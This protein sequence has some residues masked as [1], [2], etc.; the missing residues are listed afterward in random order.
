MT[1]SKD[2]FGASITE[3]ANHDEYTQAA[4]FGIYYALANRITPDDA[5]PGTITVL[6]IIENRVDTTPDT[7]AYTAAFATWAL[8]NTP[9]FYEPFIK[10]RQVHF[11]GEKP[12]ISQQ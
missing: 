7:I 8:L 4:S 12:A 3:W 10:N 5:Q 1:P 9:S 2:V 11:P 6:H